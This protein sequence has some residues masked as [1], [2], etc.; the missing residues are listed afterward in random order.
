MTDNQSFR[1]D[2][3][4]DRNNLI[5][6]S[7]YKA[8]IP[9]YTNQG[10]ICHPNYRRTLGAKFTSVSLMDSSSNR[11]CDS[12]VQRQLKKSS[13]MRV[14][15]N[16]SNNRKFQEFEP[17]CNTSQNV[18][19]LQE[20][21]VSQATR[22]N[23][24]LD[25]DLCNEQLWL[26][27]VDLQNRYYD[28]GLL[29]KKSM[30]D[31]KLSIII[32]ALESIPNSEDLL[33]LYISIMAGLCDN[34]TMFSLFRRA[35]Q[36]SPTS[37]KIHLLRCRFVLSSL[38]SFSLYS[39]ENICREAFDCLCASNFVH[40]LYFVITF[41]RILFESGWKQKAV[42]ICQALVEFFC[43]RI[44]NRTD[45]PTE[46]GR[47][48][49]FEERNLFILFWK[50]FAPRIGE[51]PRHNWTDWLVIFLG[52]VEKHYDLIRKLEQD[53][54]EDSDS[55]SSS[56]SSLEEFGIPAKLP[57]IE[58]KEEDEQEWMDSDA[59]FSSPELS[60]TSS[61]CDRREGE[62]NLL[63][64]SRLVGNEFT[65]WILEEERDAMEN[66]FECSLEHL[67]QFENDSLN[68]LFGSSAEYYCL[69]RDITH[70][71]PQNCNIDRSICYQM[72]IEL[73][74][75]LRGWPFLDS[76][77]SLIPFDL[78]NI[79]LKE[80]T[81]SNSFSLCHPRDVE[82]PSYSSKMLLFRLFDQIWPSLSDMNRLLS[83]WLLGSGYCRVL[84]G[85]T[86]KEN[87]PISFISNVYD[88]LLFSKAS[89][90]HL[91]HLE[92]RDS[93]SLRIAE[94]FI[95]FE[96]AVGGFSKGRSTAKRL[97]KTCESFS[98][99]TTFAELLIHEDLLE[100][101]KSVYYSCLNRLNDSSWKGTDCCRVILSFLFYLL[102]H[103]SEDWRT[104]K[105]KCHSIFR[106]FI[107][108]F[109][110]IEESLSLTETMMIKNKLQKLSNER[111][112][113]S[114]SL[115]EEMHHFSVLACQLMFEWLLGGVHRARD[116]LHK[117]EN[118][119]AFTIQRNERNEEVY[120]IVLVK[121]RQ[122]LCLFTF[123]DWQ[124]SGESNIRTIRSYME[125][126]LEKFPADELLLFIFC[127]VV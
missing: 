16:S 95:F 56:S 86:L 115:G 76:I 92:E 35:L 10:T 48:R 105:T 6:E 91:G 62:L 12:K 61:I 79:Q 64:T 13:G 74:L 33:L 24:E 117:I 7:L 96:G 103:V 127:S 71:I 120:S 15:K 60:E 65:E 110:G 11:F 52:A 118:D 44:D 19:K 77:A 121:L 29:N 53:D 43:F 70:F 68:T 54:S 32:K 1:V 38:E 84:K 57:S 112:S 97:L 50:S 66:S 49:K 116:V 99:Y 63:L 107:G 111:M 124:Y 72:V 100:E 20:Q 87:V 40:G 109:G 34:E 114:W 104:K 106:V 88:S 80:E 3:S 51:M 30:V 119:L 69:P 85:T 9:E 45:L 41:I 21:V 94:A 36:C 75:S 23:S 98:L 37:L 113:V 58:E 89:I 83:E 28:L 2:S 78:Q 18:E 26:Q 67:L 47:I 90:F 42:G 55:E 17:L 108:K 101:S 46:S 59:S 39:M 22:L 126:A 8:D 31:K 5:F 122:L 81:V 82:M 123:L 4:G 27:L 125:E 102:N 93:Y 25:K 73:L 14:L